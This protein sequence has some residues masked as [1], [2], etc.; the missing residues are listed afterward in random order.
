MKNTKKTKIVNN[1]AVLLRD[2]IVGGNMK[3]AL[4][5]K[6]KTKSD[7]K[8]GFISLECVECSEVFGIKASFAE[9]LG[10]VNFHYCCPYCH[11]EGPIIEK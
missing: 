4:K 5:T 9:Q 11:Y 8:T 3:A 1:G 7:D 10:E 2:V 6:F